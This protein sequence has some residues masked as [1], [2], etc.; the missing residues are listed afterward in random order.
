MAPGQLVGVRPVRGAVPVVEQAGAAQHEGATAHAHHVGAAS[1]GRTQPLGELLGHGVVRVHGGE[2]DQVGLV[3]PVQPVG[4]RQLETDRRPD[5]PGGGGA[6]GEV[7]GRDQGLA[8]AAQPEHLAQHPE[9]EG[10]D[11]VEHRDDDVADHAGHYGRKLMHCVNSA[12]GGRIYLVAD[13]QP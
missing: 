4:H 1:D 2:R 13:L 3:D 5:L 7:E 10:R 6:Q 9:L 8:L 12:T 11:A